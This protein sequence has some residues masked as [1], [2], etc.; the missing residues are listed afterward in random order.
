MLVLIQRLLQVGREIQGSSSPTSCSQRVQVAQGYVQ[1]TFEYLEGQT[2]H[3]LFGQ[4]HS[5]Y[6]AAVFQKAV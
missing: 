5:T 1:S 4:L 2:F 3:N 6:E